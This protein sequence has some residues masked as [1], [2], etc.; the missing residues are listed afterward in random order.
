MWG[1]GQNSYGQLGN[2][3]TTYQNVP[4]KIGSETDW[5]D[6]S[7][8]TYHTLALKS[9]GSLWSWGYNLYGELGDS[10]AFYYTPTLAKPIVEIVNT[11]KKTFCPGGSVVLTASEGG[12]SYTWSTGA[13]TRSITANTTGNYF[14]TVT[15]PIGDV[16]ISES[17]AV[18]VNPLPDATISTTGSTFMFNLTD[19]KTYT[20][21]VPVVTGAKYQWSKEGAVISGATTAEYI[22]QA[23]GSYSVNVVSPFGCIANSSAFVVKYELADTDGD[24]IKDNADKCNNTTA[25][26]IIDA[27]GCEIFNLPA[28]NYTIGMG[29]ATCVGSNNGSIQIAFANKNYNY[30]IKAVGA[31]SG[32]SKQFTYN[33]TETAALNITGLA[34][35]TYSVCIQVIGKEGYEQCFDVLITEP[36]ALKT[37][38]TFNPNSNTLVLN[39]SGSESYSISVNGVTE[40][41][42]GTTYSKVLSTGLNKISVSTDLGCQGTFDQ[43]IFI[44]EQAQAYPNPTSGKFSIYVPGSDPSVRISIH[45]LEKTILDESRDLDHSRII[46]YDLSKMDAGTYVIQVSGSHVNKT[47]KISKQ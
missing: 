16:S 43:E 35:D 24:G 39:L 29:S 30:L 23:D 32:Y 3:T 20:L 45:T 19:T 42:N 38:S 1:W 25:G 27:N 10:K 6:I 40:K 34:K 12:L 15:Y 36:A 18:T 44:S 7:T 2:E 26:A 8:G 46:T 31:T 4:V 5:K 41:V 9:D 14:V 28:K 21:K 17:T 13:K 22:P 11:G 37:N 47:L 33:T